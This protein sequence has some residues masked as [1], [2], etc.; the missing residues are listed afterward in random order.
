MARRPANE[1][2]DLVE[3]DCLETF[4]HPRATPELIGQDEALAAAAGAIRSGRMHHAWLI[5]GPKGIGKATLAYR[6]ARFVFAHPDPASA[7]GTSS[8]CAWLRR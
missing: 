3:S 6:F 8:S 5:G 7:D 2:D 1:V 4:P